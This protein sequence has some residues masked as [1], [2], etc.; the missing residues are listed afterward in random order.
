MESQ[1][2]TRRRKGAP[3]P[4]NLRRGDD[5]LP[6]L[7]RGDGIR[8]ERAGWKDARNEDPDRAVPRGRHALGQEGRSMSTTAIE[9]RNARRIRTPR[10]LGSTPEAGGTAR[11]LRARLRPPHGPTAPA[12]CRPGLQAGEICSTR[13]RL[14]ESYLPFYSEPLDDPWLCRHVELVNNRL[15]PQARIDSAA[16]CRQM[17]LQARE[18]QREAQ[19]A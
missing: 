1:T 7:R 19:E 4:Y 11:A 8:R 10:P 2:E 12:Q 16:H 5:D 14:V 6:D 18:R 13:G 9:G 3:R 15:V 17:Y